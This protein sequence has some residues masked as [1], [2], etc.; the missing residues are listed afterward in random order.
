MAA[1][2]SAGRPGLELQI[3]APVGRQQRRH[4]QHAGVHADPRQPQRAPLLQ[5]PSRGLPSLT[6]RGR[7]A[8]SYLPTPAPGAEV[9]SGAARSNLWSRH[10][11]LLQPGPGPWKLESREV[12]PWKMR[13]GTSIRLRLQRLLCRSRA[14][15]QHTPPGEQPP[16]LKA[17]GKMVLPCSCLEFHCGPHVALGQ[18]L[19]VRLLSEDALLSRFYLPA[20]PVGEFLYL[21]QIWL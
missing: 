10:I 3:A 12:Q 18:A 20:P 17:L 8:P 9:C 7:Q 19:P 6:A 21:R 15:N 14:Q 5:L 16:V 11:P 2:A 4:V 13:R 1:L